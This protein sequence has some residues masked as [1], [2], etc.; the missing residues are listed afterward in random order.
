MCARAAPPTLSVR[1]SFVN[2]VDLVNKM[3]RP[4]SDTLSLA[5]HIDRLMRRIHADLRPKAMRVDEAKIGP[6]G[7]MA[8]MTIED[9]APIAIHDLARLLARDKGQVT[10][11]VQ[12]LERKGLV[13]RTLDAEDGRVSRLALTARGGSQVAAF[14]AAL[15]EVVEDMLIDIAADEKTQLLKTLQKLLAAPGQGSEG[16]SA[17]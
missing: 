7:G 12:T 1:L 15:A 6:L 10:R 8:L 11:F 3:E 2:L 5:I 9:N 4:L 13:S 16:G 14:R 17:M